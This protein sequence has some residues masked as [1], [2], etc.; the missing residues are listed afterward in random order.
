[1]TAEPLLHRGLPDRRG[2][3][4]A[5][6]GSTASRAARAVELLEQVGIPDAASRRLSHLSAPALGRH[7]PARDD[8]HGMACKPRLLIADEPTTALDVTIQAQILDLLLGL[9]RDTRHGAGADHARPGRGGRDR[10]PRGGAVRRP[11]G[12]DGARR[13]LFTDPHHPYTAA[14]LAALPERAT[15]ARWRPSRAWCRGWPTGPP[16]CLFA[17]RCARPAG[18]RRGA[19]PCPP[20]WAARCATRRC[21]TGAPARGGRH[22]GRGR[23]AAPARHYEVR[24]GLFARRRRCRRSPAS[25]S[26]SRRAAPG[27]GRR[28][29]LRQEH[30]GALLTMIEP[31]TPAAC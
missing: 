27:R 13:T 3:G 17:P 12:G 24:R 2:A 6:G 15:A 16:G 25:A 29:R 8:R 31:P 30:A 4:H 18:L 5:P 20:T 7:V 9:Q 10:R 19:R 1:M 28:D 14:L 22:D 26:R 11:P 21:A 23:G